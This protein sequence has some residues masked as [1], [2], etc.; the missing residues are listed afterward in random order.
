MKIY[1]FLGGPGSGKGTQASILEKAGLCKKISTGDILRS[2]SEADTDLARELKA[3]MAQGAFVSDE[4]VIKII[5][6]EVSDSQDVKAFLFDGFPRNL[7]QA[8]S[9]DK[10]LAERQMSVSKVFFFRID[11]AKLIERV[12]SRYT[13]KKCLEG[14]NTKFKQPNVPG[15]CDIC[16]STEF[17]YREDDNAESVTERLKKFSELTEPLLLYY[18]EKGNLIEIDAEQSVKEVSDQIK[19]YI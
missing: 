12:S 2:A 13:C 5:A 10:M 19:L 18:K 16:G 11:Q 14:Y 7:A 6:D 9:L 4:I 15:V 3:I 1:I 8:K 17:V